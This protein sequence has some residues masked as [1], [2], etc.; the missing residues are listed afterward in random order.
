MDSRGFIS[1]GAMRF[2]ALVF[3]V[4]G[5]TFIA[6]TVALY[7]EYR[8]LPEEPANWFTIAAVNS[9]L[10]IFFPSF[11][12]LALCA[13][14]I[15]AAVFVDL[16]WH[17]V[18][19]GRVRFVFGTMVVALASLWIARS[20]VV[21]DVPAVWWLRPDTLQA[22]AG[23]PAGCDAMSTEPGVQRAAGVQRPSGARSN[24]KACS[25]VPVL[26][27]LAGLRRV[28]QARMGLSPFQRACDIDP[29]ME[30]PPD[31]EVLRYCFASGQN[32]NAA[33]CCKAQR[34][35]RQ[36]LAELFDGEGRHSTTGLVHAVVLPFKVMF[37]LV[38]LIIGV[39]LALWRR[40]VDKFYSR[41]ARRMERGIVVGAVAM[42]MWPITNH[43][44]LQSTAVLYG[45]K[46][47]GVY[48]DL[49]ALLSLAFGAWA[50]L[51]VLFFFR[52]HQRD[53]EAAGKIAGALVSVV[54]VLKYKELIDYSVRFVGAGAQAGEVAILGLALVVA[55]AALVWG[56]SFTEA[57]RMPRSEYDQPQS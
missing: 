36:D 33:D 28:S 5:V 45:Q 44:F 46:G 15:P 31:I 8:A 30:T 24:S 6:T 43:A 29:Y 35:F 40:T 50:L 52:Q 53:V 1:V 32:M 23:R 2:V 3:G 14:F 11:G 39:M 37:L 47:Q 18:P 10:F 13:F 27:A 38:V 12:L 42:L 55:F 51:L 20:L 57:A 21:S 49:S 34:Q 17:H 22:D 26:E 4:A 9:H 54:A 48:T 7:M 56:A 41:Y 25:R 19:Y 16:Y